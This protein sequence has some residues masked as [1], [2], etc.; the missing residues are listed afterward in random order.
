MGNGQEGPD[1]GKL[2]L[3]EYFLLSPVLAELSTVDKFKAGSEITSVALS[4]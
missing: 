3:A 4:M 1:H 2:P